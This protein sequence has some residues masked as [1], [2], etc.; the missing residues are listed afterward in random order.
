MATHNN[1]MSIKC[2]LVN[3]QSV[4]NKTFNLRDLINSGCLDILAVTETWLRDY[5]LAVIHEMTPDTHTFLHTPRPNAR[6]GGVGVF[7]SRGF[8]RIRKCTLD[9][10]ESYEVLQVEC[11]INGNRITLIILYRPPDLSLSSF[12]EELKTYLD[13]IDMVGT[14][15]I[16]CGDFN[17][18][19][20]DLSVRYV[21][22]FVDVMDS[23]N[24]ANVVD[25]PTTIGGH[26][27][28]LVFADKDIN[29]VQD[30][31]VEEIF[32]ISPVH[33]LIN[34]RV[35]LAIERKQ[36]RR[37]KF[38]SKRNF[39]SELLLDSIYN[40]VSSQRLDSCV[41]GAVSKNKCLMCLDELFNGVAKDR[42]EEMCPIIEKEIVIIDSVPWY[43]EVVD[44]AKKH[45]K[46]K[47][48]QWRRH[49]TELSRLEYTRA[50]NNEKTVITVRKREY[51]QNKTVQA[52][53]NVGKLY[54]ILDNITG[55]KKR[56][57]LPE[58]FTDEELANDFI[59]FFDAKIGGIIRSFG[60][61]T[62]DD[63]LLEA[64]VPGYR[65]TSFR[66][67]TSVSLKSI[68]ERAKP[69]YCA[70]DPLPIGELL[71]N[72]NIDLLIEI[73]VDLV[74][75]SIVS[76]TFPDMEKRAIVKPI[77]KG[78]LDPQCLSSF[79]PVSNLTFLSKIMENVILEQL[80]E[81]LQLVEALPDNQSAYRRLYSTETALC[82]VVNDMQMLM[83]EGKCGILILLDLSAAFDTVVHDILLRDCEKIGIEGA[84]LAYLKSYLENRTYCV[85]IGGTLSEVKPLERGVPQGSVLGPVLF[86]I[87]TIELSYLL[88]KH[89][90]VFKLFADDTQFYLSLRDIQD[91]EARLSSIMVDI[92][93]WMNCKQLKLNE[94]K[95]ECLV[96]GRNF[97]VNRYDVRHLQVNGRVMS[98][99]D[100]VKDL[101]VLLD[102]NLS[103]KTQIQHTVCMANYHMKNLS[104]VKKYLD[105]NQMLMLIHNHVISKLDYCNSLY[106]GVPNYLLRKLQLVMN[107]AARLI[108]GLSWRD[109]I[110]PA[111]IDLHWLPIKARIVFKRCVIVY[112]ALKSGRPGYMRELLS[113][114]HVDTNVTLRHS[115][116]EYRLAEPRFNTETG[117]K[118]FSR[119]APCLYNML[120]PT[121]KQADN[122][123]IFKKKLKTFLFS[124][125]YDL[126]SMTI[127]EPYRL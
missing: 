27:V 48:R 42:Y 108:K 58:G 44:R 26:T 80:S 95:T 46:R 50:R 91:T 112:Q 34:F 124:Q 122:V 104:F 21:S 65:L 70:N 43:N 66:P 11:E 73:L 60:D 111:L 92:G 36:K 78:A 31:Q 30:V 15:V 25:E 20:D 102:S 82:S 55:R 74:N 113:D 126:E 4:R 89:G 106:Y 38:R 63:L 59:Q 24:L 12:I 57:R 51:Y 54:K 127:R 118:A 22:E 84:A 19:M 109:R 53:D 94:G 72:D 100:G 40:G 86:C 69:T 125:C 32:S 117:R 37:I 47:E 110:T 96:I 7:L 90:V 6:G 93:R 49:K 116:E 23:F 41:H 107:R 64:P 81:H 68:I 17:I 101:G 77:L 105:E 61:D 76:H 85:Q 5:E 35:Q 79:R 88:A 67:I 87:Y 115:A 75:I 119:N 83:D 1:N 13:S 120:P 99:S 52:A 97:D 39:N 3:I 114:F 121:I 10:Q 2:G 16:V 62:R 8:K 29:L 103:F 14:D 33:K 18:W 123:D 71:H 28:D 9:R 45:K 56:N 98:V